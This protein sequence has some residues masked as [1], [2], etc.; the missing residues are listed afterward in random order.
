[1]DSEKSQSK[2]IAAKWRNISKDYERAAMSDINA[3][4]QIENNR[5]LFH[6]V[7]DRICATR[8]EPMEPYESYSRRLSEGERYVILTWCFVAETSNGGIHQFL[9]N[10][11]GDN[12]EKTRETL[13]AIG[14]TIAAQTL[15][16]VRRVLFDGKPI[17]SDSVLREEILSEWER[18]HPEKTVYHFLDHYERLL[19]LSESVDDAIAGYIRNHYEMFC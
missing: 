18:K 9:T 11:T 16:A 13:Y 2:K 1:M 4:F 3:L 7:H 14:A 5:E 17:P 12:A 19:G 8:C 10:A 6:K 15:D